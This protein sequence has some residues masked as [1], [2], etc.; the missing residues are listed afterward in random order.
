MYLCFS[1]K[2][3]RRFF[4]CTYSCLDKGAAWLNKEGGACGRPGPLGD[5]RSGFLVLRTAPVLWGSILY[6]L[7]NGLIMQF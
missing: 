7:Q 3:C 6:K 4:E 1:K 2:K 5:A